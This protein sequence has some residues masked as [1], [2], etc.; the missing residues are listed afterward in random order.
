MG[1][2]TDQIERHIQRQRNELEDNFSEL[3]RKVREAF[4][5][6]TQFQ[7]H[8]GRMLGAALLGGALVGAILPG[9]SNVTKK[10]SSRLN[11]FTEPPAPRAQYSVPEPA[12]PAPSWNAYSAS[13]GQAAQKTAEVWDNLKGAVIGMAAARLGDAI[14]EL[15]PGFSEHYRKAAGNNKSGRTKAVWPYS[16]PKPAD[17]SPSTEASQPK[18]NGGSDYSSHS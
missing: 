14:E 2:R 3:E 7:E 18:P 13:S 11:S 16:V 17:S 15:V 12:P 1:E 4:D 9:R 5:W 8:P 10:V 6:R